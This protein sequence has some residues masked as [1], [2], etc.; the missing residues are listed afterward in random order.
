MDW[1]KFGELGGM[2]VETVRKAAKAF[3]DQDAD[4][5]RRC[6]E[7]EEQAN[8]LRN[9]INAELVQLQREGRLPLEALTPLLTVARRFE[10]VTDQAKNLCEEVLYMCTG[11]FSK[12]KGT[13]AFR[14]VFIDESNACLGQMAEGIG[15]ALCIERFVFSSAGFNPARLDT[16]T[17]SFMAAKGIDVS[18]QI[19][20]SLDQ[21][22][23]LDHYQVMVALTDEAR[24]AFPPPPTKS[25]CLAWHLSDPSQLKGSPAQI[26]AAYQEAYRYLDSHIRDLVEGVL[27]SGE[28]DAGARTAHDL[29]P[30][31][32]QALQHTENNK[33]TT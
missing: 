19:A 24:K 15:S 21:V 5:A 33:Q 16:N 20:K 11:E 26:E 12:H 29:G 3:L 8:V 25:I 9:S 1:T 32:E 30:L 10:R 13:E 22:P 27:G 14:V 28:K 6:M 4:L 17:V 31:G 18:R 23:C 7:I 2:A